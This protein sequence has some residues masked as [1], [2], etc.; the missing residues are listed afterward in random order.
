[1]FMDICQQELFSEFAFHSCLIWNN[2]LI[3][4]VIVTCYDAIFLRHHE[5]TDSATIYLPHSEGILAENSESAI[6]S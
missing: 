4:S 6:A 5:L 1:M 3:R 2:F